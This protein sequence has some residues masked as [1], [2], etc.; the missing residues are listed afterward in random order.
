MSR[1]RKKPPPRQVAAP[2]AD[3]LLGWAKQALGHVFSDPALLIEA[4]SHTSAGA[5]NYQRLEFLGDRVLGCVMAAWLFDSYADEPEGKLARRFADLVRKGACA[6]VARA[7]NAA[8][9]VCIDRAAAQARVHLTE[10]V[11]GDVC[12][13]LIGALYLDGGLDAA[14]RFIRQGWCELVAEGTTAPKDVKSGLQE[15]AQARGLPLPVYEMAGR[16]GPDHAPLFNVQVTVKG[17][18]PVTASGSSKQEAEKQAA[19]AL[20]QRLTAL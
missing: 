14:A 9:H 1:A 15:W 10:N 19:T 11:L 12:E 2:D 4:L 17:F 3:R 20:F 18:D 7:I 13:A 5:H 6:R 16:S 8:E